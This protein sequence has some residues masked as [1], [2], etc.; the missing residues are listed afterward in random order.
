MLPPREFS[1]VV[2][3]PPLGT[4]ASFDINSLMIPGRS[5]RGICEGDSVA[6]EFIPQLIELYRQGRFPYDR[7]IKFYEFDDINTAKAFATRAHGTAYGLEIFVKRKLTNRF[8]GF[9]SYTLSRSTRPPTPP[10]R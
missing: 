9:L 8:G 3:A 1:G 5:I 10:R 7:L 4:E 2:G 6:T